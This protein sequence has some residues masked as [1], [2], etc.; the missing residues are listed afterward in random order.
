MQ[1]LF[2]AAGV[3]LLVV[4]SADAAVRTFANPRIG[5]LR[6]DWCL[7]FSAQ[8]GKPAADAYCQTRGYAGALNFAQAV[9]AWRTRL[10]NGEGCRGAQCT[11]FAYIRCAG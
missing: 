1:R 8:C 9:G 11:S 3:M 2:L 7:N 5:G 10:I 6:L 4:S